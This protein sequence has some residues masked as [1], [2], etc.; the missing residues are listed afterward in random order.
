[1][2]A[3]EPAPQRRTAPK[4]PGPAGRRVLLGSVAVAALL[5]AGLL[6]VLT[7]RSTGT[8][9][10][11]SSQPAVTSAP[12]AEAPAAPAGAE[13]K[14]TTDYYALL[15]QGRIDEGFEWLSP[16]YQSRTGGKSSYAAFWRTIDHV[17]VVAVDPGSSSAVVTLR[18]TRTDGTVSTE[19][20]TLR[21][22]SD[23]A[24]SDHLL[25]DDYTLQ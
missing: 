13:A 15:D 21:F 22:V 8:G 17:E 7:N 5:V 10:S 9:S 1:V 20:A 6:L 11:T 12:G 23:P 4:P 19:R 25:I 24:G 3:V 18:Y 2:A 14:T 16:A